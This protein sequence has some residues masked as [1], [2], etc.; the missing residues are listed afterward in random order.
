MPAKKMAKKTK[1]TWRVVCVLGDGRRSGDCGH[2]HR[3]QLAAVRCPYEPRAYKRDLRAEL[4]IAPAGD[5]R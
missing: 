2:D 4:R 3:T 5:A 1:R